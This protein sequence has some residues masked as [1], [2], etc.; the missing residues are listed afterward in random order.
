MISKFSVKKPFTIFVAAVIVAVFGGVSVY[1]MVPDLFPKIDTPYAMVM[2]TYP[3]ATAEEA[4]QQLTEPLEAQ[5]ATLNN[6]KN[7][8]SVS[9]DN[10]SMVWLEFTD[11]V[12][13]D[14][15]SV[16]IRDKIDQI[17]GNFP[18]NAGTPLVMKIDM[19][20]MPVVVAA[21]SME[22]K[23]SAEV[24]NFTRENL[25]SPL[26]GITGVASLTTMGMID[27]GLQIVLSQ[28][29]IDQI[30]AEVSDAIKR[31]FNKGESQI[32]SGINK[33][34]SG[35]KKLNKG[36][37]Q[38]SDLGAAYEKM[39][40][41]K[42]E[43]IQKKNEGAALKE[44]LN[45]Y[46]TALETGDASQIS[47][48]EQKMA[49]QGLTPETL[50]A[51]VQGLDVLDQQIK[52]LEE[53]MKTMEE[54]GADSFTMGTN[55]ADMAASQ[56]AIQS[57]VSQLQQS[58]SEVEDAKQAA[59]DSAD[60]TGVITMDNISAILNAQNFAMPAGYVDDGKAKLLVSVGDKIK[61][62]KELRNLVLF[63]MGIDGVDPIR[64]YDVATVTYLADDSDTYAKING[65]NGVLLSFTKQSTY[66]TAEVST[67][68]N[69]KFEELEAAN[70]GLHFT[71]LTDSGESIRMVISSVLKNLLLGG[72]LAILVLLFFLRDIRPTIIT[73]IS[74]PLSVL[75][76]LALMYFS[77]V[78][79]NMISLSGLAIGI[80]MLVDNSIVVIENTY[81]LRSLGYSAV[82]AAVSGAS[83]VAGAITSSTLTTICVFV[84]II[85][86]DGMTKDIFTDL[87]LTVTYS[88]VASLIIAL[89]LAPAMA[90]G[91]LRRDV[92]KTVLSQNGRIINRYK[93]YA[94]WSLD[95]SKVLV[96]GALV[97][98]LGMGGLLLTRGFEFMPAMSNP[99]VSANIQMPEDSTLKDTAKTND[100]I[101]EDIRKIDGVTT[102]GAMLSSDTLGILGTSAVE[103]DTTQTIMYIVLDEDSIDKG[104]LIKKKM[105]QYAKKYNAEITTSA[106][107]D[108]SD[109]TGQ[110]DV[111]IDLYCDDLDVLRDTGAEIEEE[112]SGLDSLTDVSDINEASTE[113]LHITV[114]K[115]KAMENGLTVAQVYQQVAAK[116]EKDKAA[117]TITKSGK[118]VDVSIANTTKEKFTRQDLEKMKLRV[119]KEDGSTEKVALAKISTIKKDYSLK[120]IN[121]DG[122]KRS[123]TVTASVNDG[124][125]VTK[126]TSQVRDLIRDKNL[127][128]A[129]VTVEYGGQNEEIMHSM[130]Q[131]LLMMAVGFLLVYLIMVAQFQ[132][133]RS[134][135][136]ILFTIPLAF[137]GGMAALLICGHVLSV[138]SMMGFVMLMGIVVN[139]GIVLVD[140]INRFRLEGM[141][142]RE[143]I[144]QA[145]A[146]RM[147]PVIMTAA[148]TILG[149]LP[150][151][152]GLGN[153]AEMVQP[154]AIVCIGG[155]LYATIMTLFVVP[156]MY[157]KFSR[158]HMEK[159]ADEEL[160][161]VTG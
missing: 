41:S 32:R 54:N 144:I 94:M 19:N 82:Q 138:V 146:V 95:H 102:V 74:I 26:K 97:L 100:E 30:N 36:K 115:N 111:S 15:A 112:I 126:V 140:T 45:D 151:A 18:E 2:T 17:E 90:K 128:P 123:Y 99:Q 157:N 42:E 57:V 77:G 127:V 143:A 122:Q 98:L 93:E 117:T 21:V 35:N 46:N 120:E 152:L 5:L 105:N 38:V 110:A 155:F 14:S 145:G 148:T 113:E 64:V 76:A 63:D 141:D 132:S 52:A 59:L 118:S 96:I 153:G 7:V 137:T 53:A 83:Q 33:A 89:T 13:M 1:K 72:I 22:D 139:N 8:T 60:M 47:F 69:D 108:M 129:E 133:L 91:M 31:E 68:I 101:M 84:P 16:D 20:M 121:H 65:N 87:A 51:A 3:G 149:L 86:V 37:D 134:P 161:I 158:K 114:N 55:Y 147:R 25:E 78:T 10:Y 88:L 159:I 40:R 92:S 39:R 136:I 116:L 156:V 71:T 135:F 61:D 44:L 154:V 150:L 56:S 119:E 85:F 27:E 4:E 124:Y 104:K 125:N 73:A 75:F 79:L 12:N 50:Q 80:G 49:D 28:D 109:M 11:D 23:T 62:E 34:K 142:K 67:N 29:K 106:D 48:Y 43:L 103:D 70:K 66:A 58:L 131:M 160:E 6:I 107:M 81:R 24:S 130:K 9:S